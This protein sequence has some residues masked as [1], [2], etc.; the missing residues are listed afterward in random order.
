M[1]A[2]T[3][4]SSEQAAGALKA[5]PEVPFYGEHQAGIATPV[6][7]RLHFAA[8]D[9][10]T[11]SRDALVRVLKEWTKAAAVMTAAARSAPAPPVWR[12]LRRT[13]PARRSAC[14][15]PG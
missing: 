10:S 7:D 14:R 8:F 1:A 13:T 9:V 4:D 11:T 6:Q 15:R 12:R 5:V 3:R 2:A